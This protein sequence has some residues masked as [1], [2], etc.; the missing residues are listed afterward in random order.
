MP[1]ANLTSADAR[2]QIEEARRRS[3][4][5]TRPGFLIRRLHQIHT[6]L[7]LEETQEFNITPVQYSLM[8]ALH[9]HG[10]LDQVGLA[11]EIGLER[12]NVAD[13]IERLQAR[14]LLVRRQS[15]EDRRVKLLK[16]TVKG[17]NL[18]R[19]MEAAVE[20]AHERTIDHLS[21]GERDLLLAQM[22]RLVD[23]KNDHGAAPLRLREADAA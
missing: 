19:R 2:K 5:L 4:L 11:E 22:I 16:L 14:G 1:A 23:A 3:A 7:F 20:R 10:E 12:T 6:A 15:E 9:E 18:V 13:V 21:E 17:R 8:T